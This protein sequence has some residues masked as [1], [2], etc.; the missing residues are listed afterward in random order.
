[1]VTDL[2]D[3]SISPRIISLA[4]SW[5]VVDKPS[6]WLTIPG[7]GSAGEIPVLER[8]LEGELNSR[9]WVVHRID[10]ET[11]GIVLFALSAEAHRQASLWF[12]QH[13]VKKQYDLL[14]AGAP[15]V[16]I[17][18][19][20]EPIQGA[21]S[22][23][24]VERRESYGGC[25]LARATPVTG[26]RH[27]IRIHLAGCGHPLLGDRRYGGLTEVVTDRGGK[28]GIGRVALHAARLELPGGERFDAPWPPDFQGW[29]EALRAGRPGQGC[30]GG[31]KA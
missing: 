2:V 24:Q 1:M 5:A 11:S 4:P 14:A 30:P 8:W 13:Q 17:L 10:R 9:V 6:G 22:V 12:Q 25:F 27:Q 21:P 7:R 28:I 20:R 31:K 29:V 15:G 19:I 3:H 23:T 26:R 16:P 18:R